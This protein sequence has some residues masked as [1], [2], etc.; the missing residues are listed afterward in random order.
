LQRLP[1]TPDPL[2]GNL[3]KEAW[4]LNPFLVCK[5]T[6]EFV[7]YTGLPAGRKKRISDENE[8]KKLIMMQTLL[9]HRQRY[10]NLEL[11][12]SLVTIVE[13]E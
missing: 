7:Q 4:V 1:S 6:G 2:A 8:R 11:N 10:H 5:H 12:K 13:T 9:R 3:Q